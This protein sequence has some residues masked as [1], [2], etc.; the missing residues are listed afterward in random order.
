M[1][2]SQRVLARDGGGEV[3]ADGGGGRGLRGRTAPHDHPPPAAQAQVE[4]DRVG[5][6]V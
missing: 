2:L 4:V 3:A 1:S 5:E 6:E